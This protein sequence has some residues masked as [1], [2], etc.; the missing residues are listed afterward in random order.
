MGVLEEIDEIYNSFK[1]H[2]FDPSKLLD[3][4]IRLLENACQPGN[5]LDPRVRFKAEDAC[6][7]FG[8][9]AEIF[10][11]NSF[12]S[13]ATSI[14]IG[15]WDDF[16][17]IQRDAQQRIYRA[18]LA[19]YLTKM[20]QTL[21]D[22]GSAVRWALLTQADDMLGE[23]GDEGDAGKQI[24]RTVYGMT[25]LE[26]AEFNDIAYSNLD[27]VSRR[28]WS[29]PQAFAEDIVTRFTSSDKVHAHLFASTSSISNYPLSKGYL[30]G[31]IDSIKAQT[32]TTKAKGDAL[33]DLASYLFLLI[34]G[35]LPRRNLLQEDWAFETD[36]VVNNLNPGAN[37]T[38]E[39][40][41]RN[42]LAECKNWETNRVGVSE[43]GYFLYRMRLT[44][45]KFGVIFT[46]SGISG[47]KE[48]DRA[49]KSL[50]KRAF[51]EDGSICI[52]LDENDLESLADGEFSFWSL[53]LSRIEQTRFGTPR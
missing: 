49:A 51:H 53:L 17:L 8:N 26:L 22:A 25:E 40:L 20:Y 23:H 34:P 39:L 47:M 43:V 37:L 5:E 21:G 9:V 50:I 31:L 38:S 10:L 28:D 44:H 13:A 32:Q 45:S 11:M 2:E 7:V 36:I 18:G 15:A 33:E 52:V 3:E 42:F 24:L 30:R 41:G 16:G 12:A 35:W 46:R 14:L 6:N 19:F 48:G 29:I 4:S 27:E 1:P